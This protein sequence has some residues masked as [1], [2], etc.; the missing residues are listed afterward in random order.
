MGPDL[1]LPLRS[2]ELR[3]G[4]GWVSGKVL[5][6]NFP[7]SWPVSGATGI[8]AEPLTRKE[9][10][11]GMCPLFVRRQGSLIKVLA[12]PWTVSSWPGLGG[13]SRGDRELAQAPPRSLP[14]DATSSTVGS[15]LPSSSL[16]QPG[17]N[18]GGIHQ[19]TSCLGWLVGQELPQVLRGGS[20]LGSLAGEAPHRTTLGL[21]SGEGWYQVGEGAAWG[22]RSSYGAW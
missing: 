5:L 1:G 7:G 17:C 11:V 8:P 21:S 2:P 4:L 18:C 6:Q 22:G 15:A 3:W 19:Y 12:V 14:S 10:P 20:S 16:L 9:T 13:G